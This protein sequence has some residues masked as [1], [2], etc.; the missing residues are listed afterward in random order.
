MIRL[1]RQHLATFGVTRLTYHLLTEPSYSDLV[2]TSPETVVR[3]G[4]VMA[5]RPA[6]VTPFYLL[7]L[8]GFGS[9][10]RRSM[11]L[12]AGQ[13][14]ANSP[15][16][17]YTYKNETSSL[18]IVGGR[19]EEVAERIS[20]D[21]DSQGKNLAAVITGDDSLWDVC[22]LKFI[23]E[24]TAASAKGNIQEL[25]GHGLLDPDPAMGIPAEAARRIEELFQAVE[26]GQADP[27]ILKQELDRWDIYPRYEDRFLA[28]FRRKLF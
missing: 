10:A 5:Q 25:R 15:G 21:L 12:M 11:E 18:N 7:N 22:L 4:E 1:P 27:S 8:E 2:T 6:V 17:L 26:K 16:L 3:E 14:G 23:Y 24:Y 28:I 9:E 19:S 20:K 13:F